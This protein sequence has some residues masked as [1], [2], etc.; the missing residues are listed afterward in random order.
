MILA[1]VPLALLCLQSPSIAVEPGSRAPKFSLKSL[2]GDPV[3]LRPPARG[4]I[5]I[6]YFF[7]ASDDAVETLV[8]FN[9]AVSKSS[10][11]LS[12]LALSR[13]NPEKLRTF[14]A[15]KG[16]DSVVLHDKKGITIAY[17]LRRKL[18]AAVIVG[19]GGIIGAILAPAQDANEALTACADVFLSLLLPAPA[20]NVYRAMPADFADEPKVRLGAGYASIL[21][22][23]TGAARQALKAL[24]GAA[25][26]VSFEAH[27]A[28]GFL[29]FRRR[30]DSGALAE[31]GRASGSGFADYVAGLA[32]A[33]AGLCKASSALIDRA[34]KGR[35]LFKWQEARALNMAARSAEAREDGE[36]AL[37]SYRRAASLA[38]LNSTI[39]ANLLAYHWRNGNIPAAARYA[40]IIK[41]VGSGN[42]LAEILVDEF[43]SDVE[44]K[45]DIAAQK[46]LKK[47]LNAAP[48]QGGGK[49]E[50]RA[51]SPRTILVADIDV[52]DCVPELNA[53]PLACAGFLRRSMEDA[54]PVVS[55]RRSHVVAAA[56]EIGISPEQLQNP[57][58]LQRVARALSADLMTV[59][60]V[61]NYGGEYLLNVRIVEVHSGEIIAVV[62]ER[63][64][65]FEELAP[66]IKRA[67]SVLTKKV[68]A[69]SGA[70]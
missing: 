49:T 58:H 5:L 53:L 7:D 57:L 25:P 61:G 60:E 23:E 35:F 14:L 6:L 46:R 9:E 36:A 8:R 17:G 43:E 16:L 18:P 40:E 4:E 12:L 65:S 69:P 22:G 26:P 54:G 13:A 67:A 24:T 50:S 38:P 52:M 2:S 70:S 15:G 59:A 55:I 68:L 48:K 45:T 28:L 51:E 33:R 3:S 63:F 37:R 62:S 11:A 19:Q 34:V 21:A 27:G 44:F 1:L 31:C 47:K 39:G 56:K 10:E 30:R 64:S 32:N 20:A 42:L 29:E 41:S 66:A